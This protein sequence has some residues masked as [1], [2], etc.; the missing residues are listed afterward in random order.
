MRTFIALVLVTIVLGL[1]GAAALGV[2]RLEGHIADAQ[3]ELATLKYDAAK[4][5][6]AE[7]AKYADHSRWVPFLGRDERQEIRARNAALQSWKK[8]YATLGPAQA[9]TGAAGAQ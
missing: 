2:A 4:D 9:E 8:D 6:L 3:Q 7:A 1:F 5:S